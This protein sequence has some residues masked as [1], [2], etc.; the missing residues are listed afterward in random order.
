[1]MTKH[2]FL[3]GVLAFALALCGCSSHTVRCDGK[4]APINAPAPVKKTA[5]QPSTDVMP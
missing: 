2:L 1:M 3:A 4:L 5:E